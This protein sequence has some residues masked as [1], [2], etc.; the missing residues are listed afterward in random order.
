[1]GY[2][3]KKEGVSPPNILSDN[4]EELSLQ[5]NGSVIWSEE[6]QNGVE[7]IVKIKVR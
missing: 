5:R 1:M 2:V 4:C 6:A 7:M 3:S